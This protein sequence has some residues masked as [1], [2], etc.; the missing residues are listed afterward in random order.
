MAPCFPLCRARHEKLHEQHRRWEASNR[1]A[2]ERRRA[3]S[4]KALLSTS[5]NNDSHRTY[6]IVEQR[7]T[8]WRVT[9]TSYHTVEPERSSRESGIRKS[10][11]NICSNVIRICLKI[12]IFLPVH[13]THDPPIEDYHMR[14]LS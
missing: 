10:S 11:P 5:N 8:R 4:N 6:R 1:V 7:R 14:L 9:L 12:G 13:S 2:Q 3:S